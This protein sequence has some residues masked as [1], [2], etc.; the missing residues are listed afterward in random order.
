[1]ALNVCCF[2]LSSHPPCSFWHR[3]QEERTVRPS[4]VKVGE[5]GTITLLPSHRFSSFLNLAS[6]NTKNDNDVAAGDG[7]NGWL[8]SKL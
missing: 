3:S 2:S 4:W 8:V 7:T 5:R 1:M 6:V